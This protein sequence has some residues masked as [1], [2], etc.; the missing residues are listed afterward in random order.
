MLP[1]SKRW[2]QIILGLGVSLL[3][4]ACT[5]VASATPTLDAAANTRVARATATIPPSAA[6][7]IPTITPT[8]PLPTVTPL[9]TPTPPC[10]NHAQYLH[11]LTVQDGTQFLPGQRFDKQWAVQNSGSCDWGPD[12]RLVL[13]G[14]DPLGAPNE[15]ALY[16]AKANTEGLWEIAMIA[17]Q[18]PGFYESR[19][20]AR[21][22]DGNVFGATVFVKIEVIAVPTP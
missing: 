21:D 4:G 19:W 3:L 22:P 15:V 10:E 16:P 7:I 9:P 6:P 18:T 17:P 8:P 12:Y 5:P 20:K 13:I 2:A 1:F 11:D 14:G